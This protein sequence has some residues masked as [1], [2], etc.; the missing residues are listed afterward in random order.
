MA[1]SKRWKLALISRSVSKTSH[2]ETISLFRTSGRVPAC[3]IVVTL[4][5]RPPSPSLLDHSQRRNQS[6][7]HGAIETAA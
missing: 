5:R 6:A 2:R 1:I 3:R 7:A 4:D